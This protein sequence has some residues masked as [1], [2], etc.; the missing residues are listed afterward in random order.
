MLPILQLE[1]KGGMVKGMTSEV[2]EGREELRG[3][4]GVSA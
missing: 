4:A 2:E 1:A 3:R